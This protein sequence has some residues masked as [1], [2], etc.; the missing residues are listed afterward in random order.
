[1]ETLVWA[2]SGRFFVY[3]G[4]IIQ[5]FEKMKHETRVSLAPD[6]LQ[7]RGVRCWFSFSDDAGK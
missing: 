1:M 4:R 5:D 3:S 7:N 2:L 6:S